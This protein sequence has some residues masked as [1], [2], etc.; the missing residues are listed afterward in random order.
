MSEPLYMLIARRL[1]QSI[2]TGEY[3]P[4]D[5][6][7]SENELAKAYST[8]RVT[9]RKSL[10]VLES[11][12]LIKPWHGKGYFVLPPKYSVYTLCFEEQAEKGRFRFQEVTLIRPPGEVAAVLQLKKHQMTIVTRKILEREG[13]MLAYDEKFIPYERGVPSIEFELHFTEFPDMF[14]ERFSPMSLHTE[15]TIGLETVP[16]HVCSAL[17]I[18][19]PAQLMVVSRLIRTDNEQPV[20][21]GK[22]YLTED[23]GKLTARSGYYLQKTP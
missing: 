21:Y 14:G 20:G 6:L 11:E 18:D 8:S 3:R 9:V 23:Y 5:M 4:D 12:G 15:M 22:Q 16:E 7:P 17:S 13:R 1:R 19:Y 10:G 2:L